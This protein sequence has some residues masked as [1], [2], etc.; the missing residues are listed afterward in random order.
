MRHRQ[1]ACSEETETQDRQ[2][3]H[4]RTME[5]GGLRGPRWQ[6]PGPR[7]EAGERWLVPG[8]TRTPV[9]A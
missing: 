2:G 3:D 5:L 7:S 4:G 8:D 1:Q 6:H 9:C